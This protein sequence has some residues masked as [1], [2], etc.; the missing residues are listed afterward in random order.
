VQIADIVIARPVPLGGR[1]DPRLW[2]ECVVGASVDE[3][4]LDLFR[5]VGFADV[6]VLRTFDYFS[7]SR[8]AET[9]HIA[10]SL[11]ARAIEISMRRPA[12][13]S[14]GLRRLAYRLRPRRLRSLGGRGLWG[15]AATVAAL[16]ACYGTLGLL[17]LLS[18]LGIAVTL[19][20]T[21]WAAAIAGAAGLAAVGTAANLQ[22]HRQPWPLVL[23][24]AGAVAIAYVMFGAYDPII[25]G[26]AFA[27]LVG[28]VV[29]D[30]YLLYRAELCP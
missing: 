18:L 24:A 26:L 25:E 1:R 29:F 14:A 2:A 4:Y 23:A 6:K 27:M 21:L 22:R 30:L 28:A 16:I 5:A 19:D 9:R 12:E 20:A 11:G 10:K 8:S 17:T 13:A 15:A 3:D 7:N